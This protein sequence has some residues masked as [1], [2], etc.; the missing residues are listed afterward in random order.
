MPGAAESYVSK[1]KDANGMS[2]KIKDA[3]ARTQIEELSETVAGIE[4]P[5]AP[6]VDT[7]T[8]T[9]SFYADDANDDEEEDS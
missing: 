5:A 9:L 2:Y 4:V 1:I 7:E 3:E 6:V 8:E